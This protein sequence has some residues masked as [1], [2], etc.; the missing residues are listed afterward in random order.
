MAK[1][2]SHFFKKRPKQ[3]A[4]A[5]APLYHLDHSRPMSRREFIAQGFCTGAA[6]VMGGSVMSLFANPKMAHATLSADLEALKATCGIASQGAGKIPFIVFDLAGGAN[7]AGSNVLV[8]GRGGQLDFLSTAGYSRQ[9]LPGDMVPSI[10]NPDTGLSDFVNNELGLAFH[11][12]SA[13]LHG[14]LD[15]VSVTN[16]ANINGA[17]IPA[18]SENDT[19]NNPHNP[20]YGINRAGADGSL[21]TLIGSRNSDSG[22]NSMAPAA[23]IDAAVRPTKI[24][25]PSDVT[26]LVDTGDLVGLLSQQ[27]SVAV[28]ESI[29]RISDMKL[30]N[31]NTQITADEVVKDM[32]RCG[33]VK[34][35]DITDRFGD[36][37]TLDPALD[38]VIVGSDGIFSEE[39]FS[40]DGEFRKTASVMKLVI[41]GF[42]GAGTITMG[43]YDYHD[44]SRATGEVRD[45]RAGRCMGACL[46]YAARV[47][48]PL[49]M[50]VCSDGS[51]FSNGMVD[52]SEN[53]RGKGVWTGDNSSTSASFFLVY[54]PGGAPQLIG[55]TP[56]M[57]AQHQQ[58]GFMRSDGSV[59][60]ASTP[61]A[62]N[63]NLLVET[64]I[65][66]YLA[67]HGEQGQFASMFPN[68]GLGNSALI[69]SLTAFEPIVSGTI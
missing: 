45:R 50:Y 42:A 30:N 7:I 64:I 52:D 13:F 48:M 39:E 21:L 55:A 65:L 2:T 31:V 49:M 26:G 24:D 51:V 10:A 25:R 62:N 67:L 61:A 12:D 20:M 11:S 8:G 35:A 6:T 19:G 38:P 14:I 5:D 43:G 33:Y 32:V 60:T 54:N 58:L 46:E 28:M 1:L 41:N 44:G 23:M 17:V 29:Q 36:P 63:V 47:G 27:D 4:S 56:D 40:G 22:G 18:R 69:D 68:H 34:S 59:E 15:K 16:R 57:Q 66:N 37:S 9:G 53:G 3:A